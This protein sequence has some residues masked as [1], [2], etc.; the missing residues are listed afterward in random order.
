MTVK[1]CAV[2]LSLAVATITAPAFG[3]TRDEILDRFTGQ[4]LTVNEFRSPDASS[5]FTM[6][7]EFRDGNVARFV[8]DGEAYWAIWRVSGRQICT[9]IASLQGGTLR[10]TEEEDC[11][12]VRFNGDQVQLNFETNSGSTI[13]YVGTLSPL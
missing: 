5:S 10:P 3:Q 13:Y 9:R 8:A 2:A 4:R 1:T 12:R 11:L 7:V 6:V